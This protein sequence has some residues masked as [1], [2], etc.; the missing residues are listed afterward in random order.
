MQTPNREKVPITLD[1]KIVQRVAKNIY[2][3]C[4]IISAKLSDNILAHSS[5]FRR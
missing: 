3:M 2:F 1:I 5:T 4:S